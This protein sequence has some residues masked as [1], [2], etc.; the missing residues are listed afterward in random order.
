MKS[1]L[2]SVC[3]ALVLCLLGPGKARAQV[4]FD[5]EGRPGT[6][7]SYGDLDLGRERDQQLLRQRISSAVNDLCGEYGERTISIVADIQRCRKRTLAS[8]H[9]VMKSLVTRGARSNLG[10]DSA[11]LAFAPCHV[12][13][14]RILWCEARSVLASGVVRSR[15]SETTVTTLAAGFTALGD[16]G[17]VYRPTNSPADPRPLILLL[18][19]AGGDARQF[20]ELLRPI[21]DQ[22]GFIMAAAKSVGA[23]WDIPAE[24]ARANGGTKDVPAFG[25][26]VPRIDAMLR[27]IFSRAAIDPA[28]VVLLGHSDGA[29]YALSRGLAK[30]HDVR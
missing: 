3:A 22:R 20:L 10:A 24:I 13:R 23:T 19:G 28:Q 5:E 16:V 27:T 29:S 26:D 4:Q 30:S 21:A 8:A 17:H 15:P 2:L 6:V 25:P 14:G 11:R 18:H 1:W 7:V 12:G 9:E